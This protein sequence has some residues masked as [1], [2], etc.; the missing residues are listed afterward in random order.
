VITIDWHGAPFTQGTGF[1][2]CLIAA[3][4]IDDFN[5]GTVFGNSTGYCDED[6]P[7]YGLSG[8]GSA[9]STI[10]VQETNSTSSYLEFFANARTTSPAYLETYPYDFTLGPILHYL[11]AAI[12]PVKQ[13]SPGG[14]LRATANLATGSPAPDGLPFSLAVTWPGGGVASYSATSAGGSVGF[15]LALPETAYGKQ[16][17]FVVSHPVDGTYQAVTTPKVEALVEK[18]KPAPPSACVLAERRKL[19][20]SRQFQRLRGHANRAHGTARRN[21]NRRARKARRKLNGARSEVEA[22]C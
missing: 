13:V 4:G 20:L 5:W 10:T 16:A 14:V 8:S 9:K 11:A 18:P 22:A 2:I 21:L 12:P 17:T 1:P 6:G 7:V 3:Q 15:Q 19:M